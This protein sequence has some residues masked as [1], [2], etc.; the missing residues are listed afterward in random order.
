MSNL[1]ESFKKIIKQLAIVKKILLPVQ[2]YK[3]IEIIIEKDEYF[4]LIKLIKRNII[5][6]M[7]PE[8]ILS[9][10]S[11]VD[12]FSSID[13]RTLTYLGYL[14]INKPAYKILEK[15]LSLDND[16]I[17]F[18]L[19]KKNSKKIITKTADQIFREKDIVL[20][21]NSEDS[22]IIGYTIASESILAE[23][24]QKETILLSLQK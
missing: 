13:I 19:G 5:F 20:N 16:K 18:T 3:L 7:K 9:K 14:E 10:D 24:H 22:R 23:N 15:K 6:R 8:E 11:L 2:K 21:L 17:I 12:K 4:A 1:M